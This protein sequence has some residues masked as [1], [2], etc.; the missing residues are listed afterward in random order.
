MRRALARD[1]ASVPTIQVV[2]TL[3][4]RFAEPPGPWH[5]LPIGPGEEPAVVRDWA[6]RSDASLMIAP[7]TD[8]CLE[9][10]ARWIEQAGGRSLGC[11]SD[12]IHL[13]ANK[14]RC[15]TWLRDHGVPAVLGQTLNPRDGLPPTARYPAILKPIDGAGCLHTYEVPSP[16]Q[17]PEEALELDLA[18]LEPDL[19]G[20][21]LSGVLMVDRSKCAQLIGI[22]RQSIV[23]E[24]RRLAYNGGTFP[25]AWDGPEDVLR[26][27]IDVIP[28]RQGVFGVDF[29]WNPVE[30]TIIVIEINP[31]PTTSLV[32]L[33]G[34][35]PPGRLAK[36]WLSCTRPW[37]ETEPTH[38]SEPLA[39][40]AREVSRHTTH[41]VEFAPDGRITWH[42]R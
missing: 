20:E 19:P 1:F 24:R 27:A 5:V 6:S 42:R 36:A 12:A 28:G 7:E 4:Q 38:P 8:G 21:T 9:Q 40:L 23:R 15:N 32:G 34:L 16:D 2:M 18:V 31:R 39:N 14:P 25:I 17:F 22:G 10:R 26:R 41:P 33:T 3:D 11:H 29:L 35:L 30:R 37:Y 13:T